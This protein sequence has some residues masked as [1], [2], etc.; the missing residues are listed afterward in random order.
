LLS[1][2]IPA[3][4]EAKTI[5]QILEKI[6]SVDIDKEIIVVDNGSYDGTDKILRNA[7]FKDLKIIHHITNRGKG[8]AVLT[9]LKNATGELVIIQDADLEYEPKDYLKLI[10]SMKKNNADMVLGAR[11]MEGYKGLF[12]HKLGNKFLTLFLNLLFNLKLNDCLSCYKLVRRQ[13]LNLLDL[14]ARGFDIEIEIIAKAVKNKLH[15]AQEFISYYPRS[16][17]EG[18]KI[19]IRDGLKSA[20]SIIKYRVM[21]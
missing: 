17:A 18:K 4:N 11:F 5:I 8:G 1:V 16:Y 20:L 10:E 12:I 15:I 7:D 19:R 2:I 21:Q 9:G 3:Y 6:N 13:A 14:K